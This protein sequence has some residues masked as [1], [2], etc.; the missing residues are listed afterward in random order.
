MQPHVGGMAGASP[1]RC[2]EGAVMDIGQ[3][4]REAW[5]AQVAEGD[6]WTVPVDAETIARARKG[7]WSVILTP[8][9]AVPRDWFGEIAGRDILGLASGG[10]QQMPVLAAAGAR[11]TSFD[12]SDAQLAQDR[13]VADR[14]GLTIATVQGFMHDLSAFSDDSFDLI[15]H[16]CSNCFAPEI[17]PVWRECARV[18]RPGGALL[19]GFNNPINFIFDWRAL[20]AGRLEVRHALPYSHFDLPEDERAELFTHYPMMEFSHTLEDQI[21]GQLAA[22]LHLTSMFEDDWGRPDPIAAIYKPFIA[23]RAILPA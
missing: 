14:D 2:Y 7:D 15:F 1:R 17:L 8:V 12:A 19:A 3:H 11:V 6:R 13:F 18:L 16:P 21:G 23:T 22:G 4:N 5:N 10:G 20:D 9:K